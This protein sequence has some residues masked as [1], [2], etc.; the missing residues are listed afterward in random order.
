MGERACALES[1]AYRKLREAFINREEAISKLKQTGKKTV[2]ML[3]DDVPEE[4]ILASGM[5]P[6]RLTGYYGERPNA[7]KY[8]EISFGA[9]WRGL[10]EALVNG[11]YD[12]VMDHLV[13][14]NSSDL[15]LKLYYYLLQLKKIEPQRYIPDIHYID[16]SLISRDY[17]SQRRNIR[18]TEE[19]ISRAEDWSGK[20]ISETALIEAAQLCNEHRQ[21]LRSFSALRYG[22][23]CRIT[24]VEA[25]SAIGGSFFLEKK[26]AAELLNELAAIAASWPKVDAARI[27]YTGSLQ[28]NT[29][30]YEKIGAAGGNVISEDKLFGDRYAD[31]DVNLSLPITEAVTLRY[32]FRFPSSERAFVRERAVCIPERLSEVGAQAMIIFMNHND[33]SY[34]WDF[35]K[36]KEQLDNMKIPVLIVEKQHYPLRNTEELDLKL[37]CFINEVKA[38]I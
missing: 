2:F 3:G 26:E 32:Q 4:V 31:A 1:A 22:E 30:L 9:V 12:D 37:A 36:Q 18:E 27:Y 20:K 19:F 13:M 29:E 8:L 15:I 21:A 17:R 10:F 28:E 5:Q 38:V 35:P 33:E 25:I 7:D 23:D 24:G 6:V 14:S 11:T 34:I 16:Y